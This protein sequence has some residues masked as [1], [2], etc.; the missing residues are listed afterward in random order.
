MSAHTF[1]YEHILYFLILRNICISC[2]LIMCSWLSILIRVLNPGTYSVYEIQ[3]TGKCSIYRRNLNFSPISTSN[4]PPFEK[5]SR[6]FAKYV[7]KHLWNRADDKHFK[8]GVH[9]E[10]KIMPLTMVGRW[11]KYWNLQAL[12]QP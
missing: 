3:Y 7:K 9:R 12:K 1:K 4:V 8:K 11:I 5:S 10:L 2:H 6:W